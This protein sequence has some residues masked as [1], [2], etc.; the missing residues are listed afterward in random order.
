MNNGI[1]VFDEKGYDYWVQQYIDKS[2]KQGYPIGP[3][4]YKENNLPYPNYYVSRCPDKK[5]DSWPKFVDWCGFFHIKATSIEKAKKMILDKAKNYDRPLKLE[6][7]NQKGCYDVSIQYIKQHWGSLNNMKRDLGLEINTEGTRNRP[8][9]KELFDK[10]IDIIIE[11]CTK[12]Y[13]KIATHDIIDSI[14][15]IEHISCMLNYH[16]NI[17]YNKTLGQLLQDKGLFVG[18]SGKGFSYQFKDGERVRSQYEYLFSRLLRKNGFVYNIDYK[19]DIEYRTF[20]TCDGKINCDYVIVFD[21]R[22]IYIEIPGYIYQYKVKYYNKEKIS[23]KHKE[24][25][26]QQLLK[27]EQLFIDNNLEYY[28]LFPSDLTQENL[29]AII[30]QE[31]NIREIIA[32]QHKNNIRWKDIMKIGELRYSDKVGRD[33]QKMVDYE[34]K[35]AV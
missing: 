13:D 30:N 17:L 7:F 6:D 22:T 34:Q 33:G 2:L 15:E 5:I 16:S 14:D 10:Y 11:T 27:K 8:I 29:D 9:T 28:V 4:C 19:R 20:I 24:E 25:Y 3:D 12:Y 26:K 23:T 1:S 31:D 18:E 35:E 32:S 21:D